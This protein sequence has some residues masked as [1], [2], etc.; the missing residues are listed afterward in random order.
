MTAADSDSTLRDDDPRDAH[1]S[2]PKTDA[3]EFSP[4]EHD[5]DDSFALQAIQTDLDRLTASTLVPISEQVGKFK[6]ERELGRGGFGVVYLA[7]DTELGRSVALKVPRPESMV[8]P[9]LRRRFVHEARITA[10]LDHP[11]IVPLLEA[12]EDGP[13]VYLASIYCAGPTLAVWSRDQKGQIPPRTAARL[14]M[15]LADAVQHAH[16]RGILHRDIKPSNIILTG[17]EP[18]LQPRLTDFG[19]AKFAVIEEDAKSTASVTHL[20]GWLGSPPYM[21]PEQALGKPDEIGPQ[22]DVYAIGAT[23][24]ELVTGHPPFQGPTA[25]ETIR[26][27]LDADPVRPRDLRPWLPRDLETICLKC[28]EKAPSRRY[29]SARALADDLG[30]FL[31]GEPIMARPP[32][33]WTRAHVWVRRHPIASPA[34]AISAL[35][36]VG[37]L[38]FIF[39]S[40]AW[41]RR[42]NKALEREVKRADYHAQVAI[43][44]GRLTDRHLFA[45]NLRLAREAL[46]SGQVERTQEI[47]RDTALDSFGQDQRDFAWHFLWRKARRE[48]VQFIDSDWIEKDSIAEEP[49]A[50]EL[51]PGG[52]VRPWNIAALAMAPDGKSLALAER[53]GRVTLWSLPEGKPRLTMSDLAP[54]TLLLKFTPDGRRLIALHN[55]RQLQSPAYIVSVWDPVLG[56]LC[57]RRNFGELLGIET[58]TLLDNGELLGVYV[59]APG[60]SRSLIAWDLKS[61]PKHPQARWSHTGFLDAAISSD[62]RQIALAKEGQFVLLDPKTGK[63]IREIPFTYKRVILSTFS[64]NNK[65]LAAVTGA[66]VTVWDIEHGQEIRRVATPEPVT[67]LRFVLGDR[68]RLILQTIRDVSFLN[69]ETGR[70]H[71]IKLKKLISNRYEHIRITSSRDG[72]KLALSGSSSVTIWNVASEKQLAMFPGRAEPEHDLLTAFTNDGQS[73]LVSG[74]PRVRLW[75]LV[76]DVG[77]ELVLAGHNDEAW[78]VAFR[79]DGGLLATGSDNTKTRESIK[80][81]DPTSS[82]LVTAWKGHQATVTALVFSPDGKTLASGSLEPTSNITLW[83]V[84]THRPLRVLKGHERGVGSLIFSRD[85]NTLVSGGRD[86]IIRLWKPDSGDLQGE[87]KGHTG[88]IR[89][90]VLGPDGRTLVS[91]AEDSTVRFWDLPTR[92]LLATLQH[93]YQVK[94]VAFAPDGQTLAFADE[95]GTI[96]FLDVAKRSRIR[97]IHVEDGWL[98]TLAFSPDGRTVAAAGA[99]GTIRLWDTATGQEVLA[100]EGHRALVNALAFSPDGSRIAS[101]DHAGGVRIWLGKT[102]D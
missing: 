91:A 89:G 8:T 59:T 52:W 101:C 47:L 83:D 4:P 22:T 74:G 37:L 68:P 79:P 73:L 16:E 97:V 44:R 3:T 65:Y 85:G 64:E 95:S 67:F 81:W 36:L 34:L 9:D 42:Y 58:P 53:R 82:R 5:W 100:L 75:R 49:A 72:T 33:A 41:L 32:G 80:L 29:S 48:V 10:R 84:A 12:G 19:L 20:G 87:L 56:Q 28:L 24:Y 92:K 86:Y 96:T 94:S 88:R 57:A 50:D 70:I 14:T 90:I 27:V 78:S 17:D 51:Q 31:R 77:S 60:G 39:W 25:S 11:N 1:S 45:A 18:E 63:S 21:A 40:N 35:G 46:A 38:G 93:H 43:D 13:I 98:L 102:D 2:P 7:R 30:R 61:D 71:L 69:V 54:S 55:E 26:Q 15:L 76:P 6:I 62:G 99:G 66:E 23:L